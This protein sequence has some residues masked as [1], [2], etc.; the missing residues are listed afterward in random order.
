MLTPRDKPLADASNENIEES[1]G[2]LELTITDSIEKPT[3]KRTRSSTPEKG[4]IAVT[5]KRKVDS[6]GI[7]VPD[8]HEAKATGRFY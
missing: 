1:Y 4:G 3:R 6:G 5:R 7:E 2:I 8:S